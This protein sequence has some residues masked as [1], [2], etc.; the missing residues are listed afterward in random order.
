MGP[1][2]QHIVAAIIIFEQ[3]VLSI[4]N[5]AFLLVLLDNYSACWQAEYANNFKTICT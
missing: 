1:I 3:F 2:W 4:S 5:E